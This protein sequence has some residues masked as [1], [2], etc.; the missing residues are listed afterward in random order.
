MP[1]KGRSISPATAKKMGDVVARLVDALFNG[2][3]LVGFLGFFIGLMF[4][5]LKWL[6]FGTWNPVPGY[7]VFRYFF[8]HDWLES[9]TN[10][11][12][13]HKIVVDLLGWPLFVIGPLMLLLPGVLFLIP[14]Q[15]R[16]EG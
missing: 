8:P 4:E 7:V 14:G 2:C 9:P 5:T 6:K 10:W 3:L 13:L 16:A 1:V 11:L 12:G 15:D